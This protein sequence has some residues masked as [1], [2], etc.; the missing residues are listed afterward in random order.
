MEFRCVTQEERRAPAVESSSLS[1]VL[2]LA[3]KL[4]AESDGLVHEEQVVEMGRELGVR[5]EYVR[6]AIR[7]HRRASP[8]A[9]RLPA[10]PAPP[11]ADHHPILAAAQALLTIFAVL[12]LPLTARLLTLSGRDPIWILVALAGAWA[13]GWA[14]RQP[15]LA[16]VAGAVAVPMILYVSSFYR[17]PFHPPGIRG[18]AIFFSLLSLGP[19]CAA[20]GEAA[21]RSRRRREYPPDHERMTAH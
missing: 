1:E 19:L 11:P 14:A 4:Q 16:A 5:P 2:A 20:V 10:E 17:E 18:E 21:G 13:A 8:P 7:R 15:R 12:M 9:R 3:Q 6:A